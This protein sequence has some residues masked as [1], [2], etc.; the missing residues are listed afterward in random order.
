MGL[1]AKFVEILGLGLN[2]STFL[3]QN[4]RKYWYFGHNFQLLSKIN[5]QNLGL[6]VKYLVYR[7]KCVIL[8]I[9]CRH[10]WFSGQ[11]FAGFS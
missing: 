3:G 11:N 8:L 2:L 10:I 9:F 4:L 1:K 5:C 6:E 7:L